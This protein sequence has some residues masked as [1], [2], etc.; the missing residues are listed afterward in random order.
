MVV[1]SRAQA[2]VGSYFD[3][4]AEALKDPVKVAKFKQFANTD[5]TSY[6]AEKIQERG[7]T[8]PADWPKDVRLR[9]R[10]PALTRRAVPGRRTQG[11]GH[12]DAQVDLAMAQDV[13]HGRADAERGRSD[14]R[15]RQ[16]CVDSAPI[17]SAHC[18]QG[19]TRSSPSSLSP[20]AASMR[21]S[22]CA[23]TSALSCSI[24]AL[25]ART[26]MAIV[27]PLLAR[28]RLRAEAYVSCPLHK[29]NYDLQ[30]GAC[31]NDDSFGIISFEAKEEDGFVY[32]LLPE[33]D[34]LDAVL[35]TDKWMIRQVRHSALSF[36]S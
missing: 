20:N 5:E 33:K 13:Q 22:R 7:Q 28:I 30:S 21:P 23:R 10:A 19:A 32:L 14:Q 35:S 8:R 24:T 34:D 6:N 9:P 27:R 12:R 4:W 26:R 15:G 36:R 16:V 18:A 17:V 31:S 3:E 1:L 2:Y 29:R 25:S 11:D